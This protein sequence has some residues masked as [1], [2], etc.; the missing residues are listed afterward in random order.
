[1]A[2]KHRSNYTTKDTTL[3]AQYETIQYQVTD[4]VAVITLNRPERLNAWMPTMAHEFREAMLGAE[5][6]KNVV[7]VVVTGSG[8]AFC[9][10]GDLKAL[11]M[12]DLRHMT[13]DADE[14]LTTSDDPAGPFDYM[15][16]LRKPVIAAI[17]GPALGMGAVLSLWADL[18]FMADDAFISMSFSQ[19]GT[20]AEGASSW[21]LPRLI[22]T[23]PALDLL[24]SSRRVAADEALRLGLVNVTVPAGDLLETAAAYVRDL[25]KNCSPTS[26]AIIK[27]QVYRDLHDSLGESSDSS[28]KLLGEAVEGD[29]IKEGW[30]AYLEKRPAVFA[31]IGH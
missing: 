13:A 16:N 21:L 26:L 5:A 11:R 20:V 17:N 14:A 27:Q 23:A 31:R 10:G 1:M 28:R 8:R 9:A 29:D 24:L 22:G 25:S 4:P 18:R 12:D 6:D 2:S 15:L 30:Q 7:G 19:R 3:T